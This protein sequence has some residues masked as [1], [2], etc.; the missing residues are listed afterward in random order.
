[1]AATCLA[2][3]KSGERTEDQVS[4]GN[5]RPPGSKIA[6]PVPVPSVTSKLGLSSMA[7][8][9]LPIYRHL[10]LLIPRAMPSTSFMKVTGH[11]KAS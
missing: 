8:M 6:T 2:F 11:P 9:D 10:A 7:A 1:M 3:Y 5:T 4:E